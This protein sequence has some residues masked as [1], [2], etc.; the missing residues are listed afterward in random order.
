MVAPWKPT[1]TTID[2]DPMAALVEGGLHP[3]GMLLQKAAGAREGLPSWEIVGAL[4]WLLLVLR[5]CLDMPAAHFRE[6]REP[7]RRCEE[8]PE[9]M[10]PTL[11]YTV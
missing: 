7:E 11:L 6:S 1:N 5:T 9:V 2:L 4:F 10:P 3:S 8:A